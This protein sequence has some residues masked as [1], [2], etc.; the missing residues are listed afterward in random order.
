MFEN[1]LRLQIKEIFDQDEYSI[2]KLTLLNIRAWHVVWVLETVNK[3]LNQ[4]PTSIINLSLF[5]L[6]KVRFGSR[7]ATRLEL[8]F[9]FGW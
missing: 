6:V 4:M 5:K 1:A 9:L 7:L 8:P 3:N 2:S